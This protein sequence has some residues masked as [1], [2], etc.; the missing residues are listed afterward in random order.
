MSPG[1]TPPPTPS[2]SEEEPEPDISRRPRNRLQRTFSLNQGNSKPGNLLR[3]LSQR[4]P[5][6]SRD[7]P[8]VDYESPPTTASP[9]RNSVDGYFPS[10]PK[11]AMPGAPNGGTRHVSAPLPTRPVNAFLRRPTNLSVKAAAKGDAVGGEINLEHGLDVCLH[12][13]VDQRDPAGI[14]APYRLIVPALWY[15]QEDDDELLQEKKRKPSLMQRIGSIRVGGRNRGLAGNQG[16][17]N[18]GKDSE[19]GS[20]FG[21]DDEDDIGDA[22]YGPGR[23]GLG[24]RTQGPPPRMQQDTG[25]ITRNG[26]GAMGEQMNVTQ[27]LSPPMLQGGPQGTQTSLNGGSQRQVNTTRPLTL[28]SSR[29]QPDTRIQDDGPVD[30][31]KMM[32]TTQPLPAQTPPRTLQKRNRLHESNTVS[33]QQIRQTNT[34]EPTSPVSQMSYDEEDEQILHDAQPVRRMNSKFDASGNSKFF[35]T[36]TSGGAGHNAGM[37][38]GGGYSGIE[39]YKPAK[40][41]WRK[42]F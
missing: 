37:G 26:N 15:E 17:G 34:A 18:W 31:Q 36:T 24:K 39:A 8:P 19:T 25:P 32:N 9:I 2:A 22:R 20:E 7:G 30:H 23:F 40:T 4:A 13:E 33:I 1:T 16:S 41:G 10:S 3:R 11:T 28:I 6:G 14:T 35:G 21:S 27:P 29:A 12:C 5:A 38:G 42:F